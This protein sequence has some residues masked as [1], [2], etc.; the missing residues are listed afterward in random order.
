MH[1][2]VWLFDR[3]NRK[4]CDVAWK[5]S[6]FHDTFKSQRASLRVAQRFE[7]RFSEGPEQWWPEIGSAR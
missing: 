4:I 7:L 5:L 3:S 2:S 6:S 1:A